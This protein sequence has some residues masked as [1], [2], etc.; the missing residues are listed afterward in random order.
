MKVLIHGRNLELTPALREYTKSKLEKAIHHFGDMVKEA[1]VHL[2]VAKNPRVPQQTAEVTVFA[3][4]TVI[5]AQERSQNLYASIDLVS[6]K[7]C[8]QLRR[9]KE[10]HSD[11]HHSPGHRASITPTTEEVLEDKSINGSLV[12]G[13]EAKLP[14]PGIRRKYFPMHPMNIE[15][16]QH[17]LDLIDHDFYLFK[18][19]ESEQLQVIY[20]RKNGGYGVIQAK[21]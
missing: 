21:N 16:A 12:E 8:R 7:L 9:Y 6:N 20:R 3:N 18:E 4:G 15:Q 10:R 13:K 11:H 19:A 1:D 5:R 17:Q 2:S 14:K